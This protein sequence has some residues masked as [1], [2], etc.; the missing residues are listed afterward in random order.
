MSRAERIRR[1][2]EALESRTQGR[3]RLEQCW[4]GGAL[5]WRIV[6]DGRNH[7]FYTA[8]AEIFLDGAE[9]GLV[10]GAVLGAIAGV[11]S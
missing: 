5:V 2:F 4:S 6:V 8:E 11:S 3:I 9:A 7:T 1:R 10:C